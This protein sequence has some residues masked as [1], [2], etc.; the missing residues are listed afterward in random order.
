MRLGGC[1]LCRDPVAVAWGLTGDE[2]TRGFGASIHG[3][4]A[5]AGGDF[6]SFAGLKDEVVMFYFQR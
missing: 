1:S 5:L 2:D 6:D 4:M 3:L